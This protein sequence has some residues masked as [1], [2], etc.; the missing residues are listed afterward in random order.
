MTDSLTPQVIDWH[1]ENGGFAG[2]PAQ[3][4]L[5]MFREM[6]ELCIASGNRAYDLQG[7]LQDEIDKAYRKGEIHGCAMLMAMAEEVADVTILMDVFCSCN[8]IDDF[9]ARASKLQILHEREWEPDSFGVLWRPRD[10]ESSSG[11]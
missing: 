11:A 6:V 3:Q 9:E 8:D 1:R 2:Y 4:A 7:A 10:E 5:R